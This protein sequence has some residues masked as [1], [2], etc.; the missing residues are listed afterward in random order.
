MRGSI[1]CIAI[2][3][4][5][6]ISGAPTEEES[7]TFF[8][9]YNFGARDVIYAHSPF[10][11]NELVYA[12]CEGSAADKNC[13][14]YVESI[15]Q[16][17]S[18]VQSCDLSL[19][20]TNAF[21]SVALFNA[22][23]SKAIFAVRDGDDKIKLMNVNIKSC[24]IK[25]A[26]LDVVKENMPISARLLFISHEN[27]YDLFVLYSKLCATKFCKAT[28]D[29]EGNVVKAVT[30]VPAF[31]ENFV[32]LEYV[33]NTYIIVKSEDDLANIYLVKDGEDGNNVA[34]VASIESRTMFTAL[35]VD[36]NK[37]AIC[38]LGDKKVLCKQIHVEGEPS[39][40][41]IEIPFNYKKGTYPFFNVMNME[42]GLL[43][44]LVRDKNLITVTHFDEAGKQGKTVEIHPNCNYF[45]VAAKLYKNTDGQY[46][47]NSI[48]M[49]V[50]DS[51]DRY[52][53]RSSKFS[54]TN[55][56]F[57]KSELI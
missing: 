49:D 15:N 12:V 8:Q 2:F 41:N 9:S 6:Y 10:I 45:A 29:Y 21:E 32:N 48:C 37:I 23:N 5:S 43:Q 1:V 19:T 31:F 22:G 46:C 4:L 18:T 27:K 16:D 11:K 28:Y 47:V 24:Q 56:C 52:S 30:T 17:K 3:C 57:L 34:P 7:K 38:T 25:E 54:I 14:V 33:N 50:Y 26:S 36:G 42:K 55:R 13:K 51:K 40:I 44:L 20:Y 53:L 35:S 39:T